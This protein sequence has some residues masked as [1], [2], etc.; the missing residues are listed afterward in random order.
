L[1]DVV[2]TARD[3]DLRLPVA[4]LLAQIMA[5]RVEE[6]AHKVTASGPVRT[7]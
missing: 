5:D 3:Q 2:V 6:H 1:W 7:P 4:G